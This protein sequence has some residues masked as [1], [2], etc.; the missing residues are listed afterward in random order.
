MPTGTRAACRSVP[1]SSAALLLAL[2]LLERYGL[3]G[4]HDRDVVL[5]PVDELRLPAHAE[6]AVGRELESALA[7]RADENVQQLLT[8]RHGR[9]LSDRTARVQPWLTSPACGRVKQAAYLRGDQRSGS[10]AG[11]LEPGGVDG[12]D[13]PR[14]GAPAA[15]RA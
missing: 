13:V 5:D 7:H 9:L 14:P 8:D 4:K 11:G 6:L 2:P 3:V 12:S 1:V 10:T 15:L